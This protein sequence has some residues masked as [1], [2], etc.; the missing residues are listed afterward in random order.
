MCK[1]T[2]SAFSSNVWCHFVC[3]FFWRGVGV[4]LVSG[5][6]LLPGEELDDDDDDDHDEDDDEDEDEDDDDEDWSV[7]RSTSLT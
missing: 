5:F 4:A 2:N 7:V 1:S 3:G 6:R